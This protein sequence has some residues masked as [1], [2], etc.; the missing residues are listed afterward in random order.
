MSAKKWK[1]KLNKALVKAINFFLEYD[2]QSQN[3]TQ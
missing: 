3:M 1:K 2:F